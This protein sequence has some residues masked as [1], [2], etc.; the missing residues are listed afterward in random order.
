MWTGKPIRSLLLSFLLIVLCCIYLQ[1]RTKLILELKSRITS[2][3]E[4]NGFCKI[5]FPT[6]ILFDFVKTETTSLTSMLHFSMLKREPQFI[7]PVDLC[8][9]QI[10][11]RILDPIQIGTI[12][13]WGFVWRKTMISN[14]FRKNHFIR[15]ST[16]F[17]PKI[18]ISAPR[19]KHWTKTT[20]ETLVISG[21]I[22]AIYYPME[23]LTMSVVIYYSYVTHSL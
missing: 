19:F 7:L 21:L 16:R 9:T 20:K 1:E 2:G 11:K 13:P 10:L 17:R 3:P 4:L 18:T 22:E 8:V 15:I 14:Q 12:W 23:L 6:E 5:I